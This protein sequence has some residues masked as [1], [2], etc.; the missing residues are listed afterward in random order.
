M[1]WHVEILK[2]AASRLSWVLRNIAQPNQWL[3]YTIT[4]SP[5]MNE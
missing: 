5:R 1:D 2:D 4:N 3:M